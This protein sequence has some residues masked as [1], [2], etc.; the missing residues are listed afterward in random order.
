MQLSRCEQAAMSWPLD[1]MFFYLRANMKFSE[2]DFPS[3]RKLGF[4]FTFLLGLRAA[5]FYVNFLMSRKHLMF[6]TLI[7]SPNGYLEGLVWFCAFKL[8]KKSNNFAYQ[9]TC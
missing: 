1:P 3:N 8:N 7:K 2:I 6:D 4:F 5:Y 9:K